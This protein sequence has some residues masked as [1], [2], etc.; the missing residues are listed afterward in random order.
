MDTQKL[1]E[2][3]ATGLKLARTLFQLADSDNEDQADPKSATDLI[4]HAYQLLE[5]ARTLIPKAD[6]SDTERAYYRYE[7]SSLEAE[8]KARHRRKSVSKRLTTGKLH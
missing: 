7:L 5:M 2:P 8:L 6:L 4:E 1:T 3:I